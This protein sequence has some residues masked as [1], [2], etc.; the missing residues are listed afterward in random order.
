MLLYD[1]ILLGLASFPGSPYNVSR[2]DDSTFVLL[3][4]RAQDSGWYDYCCVRTS[5]VSGNAIKFDL[6]KQNFSSGQRI[7]PKQ[8]R[9]LVLSPY[10]FFFFHFCAMQQVDL[11]R[12]VNYS[13]DYRWATRATYTRRKCCCDAKL[14]VVFTRLAGLP[15]SRNSATHTITRIPQLS[16][17]K[18][19]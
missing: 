11:L 18:M 5:F 2:F 6:V 10:F 15:L 13:C 16:V 12:L 4:T 1:H 9:M 3:Q 17:C 7:C 14:K 19:V 8:Q